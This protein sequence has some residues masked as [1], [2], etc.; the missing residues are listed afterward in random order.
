MVHNII[1]YHCLLLVD[2]SIGIIQNNNITKPQYY[3]TWRSISTYQNLYYFDICNF[4]YI[5]Y[6]TCKSH[7]GQFQK[8][9]K[10][11][12]WIWEH[13]KEKKTMLG[14]N[15]IQWANMITLEKDCMPF[16][17]NFFFHMNE[18]WNNVFCNL[19]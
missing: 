15:K 2:K 6:K 14:A 4:I 1:F 11:G 16:F 5:K 9:Y 12:C 13:I 7:N 10:W 8:M 17:P 19:L 3:R 18:F